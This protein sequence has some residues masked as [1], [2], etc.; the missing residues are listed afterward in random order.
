M[1]VNF[2][3]ASIYTG[4]MHYVNDTG[5]MHYVNDALS[6]FRSE[7]KHVNNRA[8]FPATLTRRMIP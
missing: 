4:D 8:T 7:S 5:G 3:Y 1:L 6:S 2:L